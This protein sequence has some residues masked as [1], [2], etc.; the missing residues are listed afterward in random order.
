MFSLFNRY[1]DRYD[2]DLATG[3]SETGLQACVYEVRVRQPQSDGE[4]E[5]WVEAP[6]EGTGWQLVSLRPVSEGKS[7]PCLED[8]GNQPIRPDFADPP[9]NPT[10]GVSPSHLQQPT[11]ASTTPEPIVP[12][13]D[14]PTT[15]IEWGVLILNTPNPTLKVSPSH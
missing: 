10:P 1:R 5:V 12:E 4:P 7:D 6:R 14:P 2:F 15:L 9:P 11:D 3:K 13:V 8:F